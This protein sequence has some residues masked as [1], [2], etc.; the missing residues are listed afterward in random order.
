[1]CSFNY[2]HTTVGLTV[3]VV[4]GVQTAAARLGAAAESVLTQPREVVQL[5][6]SPGLS[7]SAAASLLQKVSLPLSLGSAHG[8]GRGSGVRCVE[9]LVAAGGVRAAALLA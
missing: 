2:Q 9:R 6:R 8:L 3:C 5:Y 7:A 4:C 1:M